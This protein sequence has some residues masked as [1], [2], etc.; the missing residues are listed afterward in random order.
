MLLRC[1]IVCV[2]KHLAIQLVV[3]IELSNSC[4]IDGMWLNKKYL[5]HSLEGMQIG[6]N[7]FI[8]TVF[9]QEI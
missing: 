4:Y 1:F 9:T 3:L 5:H 2:G 7:T 6:G 8:L